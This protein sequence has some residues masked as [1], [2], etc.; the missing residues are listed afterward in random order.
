VKRFA[1]AEAVADLS[2]ALEVLNTLPETAARDTEE[3]S[4]QML[5]TTP[6]IAT[7][8]YTAPEVETALYRA[9]DLSQRIGGNPRLSSIL[10]GLASF[11]YNRGE[12]PTALEL[13]NQ[14]LSFAER[15]DDPI[16]L[17]WAHYTLGLILDGLG[18]LSSSRNHFEKSIVHYNF[19]DRKSYGFVQDPGATGL[20]ALANVLQAL[21]YPEQALEKHRQAMDW[22]RKLGD[23]FTLQWVLNAACQLHFQRGEFHSALEME[24]EQIAVCRTHGFESVLREGI[25]RRGLAL[26]YV[27][28]NDEGISLIHQIWEMVKA[29]TRDEQ[30]RDFDILYL[31]AHA[32]RKSGQAI[33]GLKAFADAQTLSNER[34][35]RPVALL[36]VGFP[37]NEQLRLKANLLLLLNDAAKLTEAERLF[38]SA[39]Q[40]ERSCGAKWYELQSTT[41]LA[42]LLRD[43]GRR[44]E[45]RKILAEI[46]GWFTEGLDLPD[47]KEAK[48]LLDELSGSA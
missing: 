37:Q 42:R 41:A 14:M 8:G 32:Y 6:L 29:Q 11:Y 44:D 38:R 22:A 46:Y 15:K 27:G 16:R 13:A 1:N 21:G 47:L 7:K 26:T 2:K 12:L 18:D 17:V 5:L 39:I 48:A 31:V 35:V 45:A 10:G 4:L 19:Q 43:T 33:R 24:E 25:A 3:L 20:S 36:E 23:P 40:I 34:V 9:R 28:R 30:T